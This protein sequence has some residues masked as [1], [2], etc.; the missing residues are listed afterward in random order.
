MGFDV[1]PSVEAGHRLYRTG[2]LAEAEAAYREVLRTTGDDTEALHGLGLIAY[3]RSRFDAAIDF[4]KRAAELAPT[5]ATYP[6]N[7][8]LAARAARRHEEAVA[9]LQRA[10]ALDANLPRLHALLGSCFQSLSRFAEAAES[11]RRELTLRP[12]D[13]TVWNNLGVVLAELGRTTEAADCY[14]RAVTLDPSDASAHDNLLVT[15][16]ADPAADGPTIGAEHSAW[17]ARHAAPLARRVRPHA[18]DRTPGRRLRIGYVSPDFR[19][20]V[21][22]WSVLPILEHHDRERFEVVCYSDAPAP[23]LLT[24]RLRAHA[25]VW[26]DCG[27]AGSESFGTAN[28]PRARVSDATLAEQIRMDRI[29][30]LV[31][32]KQHEPGNR[33]LTFARKPAPV[34][35]TYLGYAAT[36][37]LPAIDFRLTDIHMDP[38]G[39]PSDG[40][41]ELLRL[42]RCYWAYRPMVDAG[43]PG[44]PPLL[45]N[46]RVTFGS[47]NHFRKVNPTVIAAWGR[48]L[49]EVPDSHLLIVL[50]GGEHNSQVRSMFEAHGVA[51]ARIILLPTQAPDA[52]FRLFNDVDISLDPFPYNGGI[53]GLNSLWMG[54][55]FVALAGNR[56]VARAGLSLLANVGL[57]DL[58]VTNVA[59]Y[60]SRII[61]LA[62]NHD[63]LAELR[64]S[65][66]QQLQHSPLMDERQFTR[67]LEALYSQVWERWRQ[68]K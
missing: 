54:V 19:D 25:D 13:A 11:Y 44:P 24:D 10:A 17:A 62:S 57:M 3:G 37:G 6:Y 2:R 40:P 55:P 46:G 38:P 29:D 20:H 51:A 32:L 39:E 33:L 9:W 67:D 60:V 5:N 41:E 15:L 68:D 27:S 63:R 1:R 65:L 22:G 50:R 21:V 14:R 28:R 49:T 58:L 52:Y 59:Q 36:T 8:A 61:H 43:A 30:I 12:D 42:P 18:N 34:Q 35:V 45:R 7:V 23:D 31:D 4:L 26:R 47:F 64:S 48:I 66:R 16:H 53:T 56:A